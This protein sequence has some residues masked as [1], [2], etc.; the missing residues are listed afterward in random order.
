MLPGTAAKIG[1]LVGSTQTL[2]G[3][4]VPLT[5][6]QKVAATTIADTGKAIDKTAKKVKQ[7]GQGMILTWQ[8]VIRIFAIQTIHQMISKI[9]SAVAE[10]VGAARDYEIALAEIQT[11][12]EP[13]RKDFEALSAEARNFSDAL[14]APIELVT[15]G[16]YQTLSH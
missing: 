1:A 15:E 8:S 14:G 3:A 5:A 16:I 12:A 10:G 9:T 4:N 2:V 7:G 13:F 6:S 11:I